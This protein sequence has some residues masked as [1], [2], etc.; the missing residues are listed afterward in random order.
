MQAVGSFLL[1]LRTDI[2]DCV[3]A[4][5]K[6]RAALGCAYEAWAVRELSGLKVRRRL[7]LLSSVAITALS[8]VF[9]FLREPYRTGAYFWGTVRHIFCRPFL[10]RNPSKRRFSLRM[11]LE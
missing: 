6:R 2:F 11:T 1:Y 7:H 5:S 10:L 3:T 8:F 4:C 9:A